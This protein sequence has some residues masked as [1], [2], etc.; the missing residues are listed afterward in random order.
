MRLVVE[1]RESREMNGER[2]CWS[3]EYDGWTLENALEMKALSSGHV[4]PVRSVRWLIKGGRMIYIGV[5]KVIRMM[6]EVTDEWSGGLTSSNAF[7]DIHAFSL[8]IPNTTL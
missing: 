6:E 2:D 3:E 5:D 8:G 7:P 1:F 4:S